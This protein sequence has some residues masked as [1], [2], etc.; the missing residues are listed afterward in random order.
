AVLAELLQRTAGFGH[1]VGIE[2]KAV[3]RPELELGIE[4]L[5]VVEDP[6]QGSRLAAKLGP[7][8]LPQ[9][10]GQRVSRERETDPGHVVPRDD[11]CD[12]GGAEVAPL[13][14][15]HKRRVQRA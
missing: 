7:A 10:H 4:E 13:A 14:L 8:V 2:E 12:A 6:E 5:W 1:P 15:G 11:S 3:A 9:Q